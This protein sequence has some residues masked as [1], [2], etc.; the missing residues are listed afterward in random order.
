MLLPDPDK[1]LTRTSCTLVAVLHGLL[2]AREELGCRVHAAQLQDVV[3]HGRLGENGEVAARGDR[4]R[5]LA[6]LDALFRE[7][8]RVLRPGGRLLVLEFA[9]P[10]SGP[11]R[12]LARFYL[13]TLVPLVT[14]LGTRS[15]RAEKVMRYCW[16]TV[17]QLVPRESVLA[18][19]GHAGFEEVSGR[20]FFGV[21]IE[22]RAWKPGGRHS[23]LGIFR[24]RG[25]TPE[26]C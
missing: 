25:D 7:C 11:G 2:L 17:D 14:R 9:R 4:Y 19:V 15:P 26:Q 21:F 1:P 10:R 8:N 6:D 13:K 24:A 20:E 5:H 22:Y 16:D 23:D 12:A 18:S 3:A